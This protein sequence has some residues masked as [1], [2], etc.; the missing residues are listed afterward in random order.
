MN[1]TIQTSPGT[2]VFSRNMMMN[3]PLMAN[4]TAAEQRRQQLIDENLIWVN[5]KQ[6][7]HNHS[8]K[9]EVM[10]AECDPAKLDTQTHGPCWTA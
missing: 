10:M 4:L 8:V 1:D 3:A 2:L 5:S 9:D 6:M 7:A